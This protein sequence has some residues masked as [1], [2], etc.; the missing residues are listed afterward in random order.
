[1]LPIHEIST[2]MGPAQSKVMIKAH[3]LT[4]ED[5]KSKVGTK[6]AAKVFDPAR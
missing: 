6:H 5:I 4:G 3:I 1:M 2:T